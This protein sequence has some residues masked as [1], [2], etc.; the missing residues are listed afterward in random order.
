[1]KVEI[2]REA[3][4]FILE[5]SKNTYPNEFA[6]FLREKS[7]RITEIIFAPGVVFGRR[8]ALL[9]RFLLPIDPS[10]CG[11]VHSHPTSTKP[12][13]ADLNFFSSFG[14]YHIL[15]CFPFEMENVEVYSK[16]GKL[17]DFRVV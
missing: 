5:A 17:L 3:L 14:K 13:L 4:D 1:M 7:G 10:I 2:E 11:S 8:G 6:A 16:K 15:V 12:S 9:S